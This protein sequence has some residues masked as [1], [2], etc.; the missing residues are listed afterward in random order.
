M[1]NPGDS[2]HQGIILSLMASICI[3]APSIRWRLIFMEYTK[4]IH[5]KI[6]MNGLN[7]IRGREKPKKGAGPR[8]QGVV[9]TQL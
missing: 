1:F 4:A 9:K 3:V 8:E 6:F 5:P 7:K 2:I